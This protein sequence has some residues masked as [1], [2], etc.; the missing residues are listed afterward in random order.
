MFTKKYRGM[1]KMGAARISTTQ[2]SLTEGFWRLFTTAR[3]IRRP[4]EPLTSHID[5]QV[6]AQQVEKDNKQGQHLEGQQQNDDAGAAEGDLYQT[7]LAAV[8]QQDGV[9]FGW[10]PL[11]LLA[12]GWFLLALW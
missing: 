2:V 6:V 3:A 4:M 7:P 10:E 1:E 9:L 11:F 8:E 5:G 12:H